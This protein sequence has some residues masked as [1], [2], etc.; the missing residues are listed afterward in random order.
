MA[1]QNQLQPICIITFL[2]DSLRNTN[3]L[4]RNSKTNEL[5]ILHCVLAYAKDI[6]RIPF[7]K[8]EAYTNDKL[9]A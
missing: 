1:D 9:A 2:G 6:P 8:V 7:P 5:L 4:S 3:D